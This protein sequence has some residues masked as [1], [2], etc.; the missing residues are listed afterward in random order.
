MF[1]IKKLKFHSGKKSKI[2]MKN[3]ILILVYSY[4]ILLI[5]VSMYNFDNSKA[6]FIFDYLIVPL[7]ISAIISGLFGII[8]ESI[9]GNLFKRIYLYFSFWKIKFRISMFFI[10]VFCFTLWIKYNYF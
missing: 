10:V 8:L 9:S 4:I 6:E 7:L 1:K 2:L 5:L 3:K